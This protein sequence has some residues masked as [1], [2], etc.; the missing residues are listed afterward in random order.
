MRHMHLLPFIRKSFQNFTQTVVTSACLAAVIL[1][2]IIQ[3]RPP[4]E[5]QEKKIRD[6]SDRGFTY[7]LN[8]IAPRQLG[9][10][11]WQIGD[12]ARYQYR[13]KRIPTAKEFVFEREVGFHIIGELEMSGSHGYWMKKTGFTYFRTVPNDIYRYVTVNDL[14]IT[15]KNL[16]YNI[17]K[18]YIPLKFKSCDQTSIPLAKLTKLGDETIETKAGTFECIH[19]RAELMPNRKFLEIWVSPAISPLGIVRV[20][21]ETDMLDLLS[22]GQETEIT[23]PKLI[24]PVIDGI[25]TL[26]RGCNSCHE[27]DNLHKSIFPPK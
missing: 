3:L 4:Q 24:Q 1:F 13:H 7:D 11:K 8:L 27:P 22:F 26:N 18:N 20:R 2:L 17:Q 5:R 19:Y 10:N 25:S 6:C 16:R 9:V 21:S 23:V 15:P 12:Y 14:R